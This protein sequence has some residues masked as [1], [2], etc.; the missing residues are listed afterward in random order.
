MHSKFPVQERKSAWSKA[1]NVSSKFRKCI[2]NHDSYESIFFKVSSG[3][4]YEDIP[5]GD[6]ALGV[7]CEG[8]VFLQLS[9]TA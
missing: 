9:R 5:C 3:F 7:K 2:Y 4:S 1:S 8:V 6:F